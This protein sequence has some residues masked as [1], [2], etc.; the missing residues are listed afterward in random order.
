MIK[1]KSNN[2]F[3]VKRT[4]FV[5]LCRA[6]YESYYYNVIVIFLFAT[7]NDSYSFRQW[8]LPKIVGLE[9]LFTNESG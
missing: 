7:N 4:K 5:E 6:L 1:C 8:I 3:V 2:E 9:S